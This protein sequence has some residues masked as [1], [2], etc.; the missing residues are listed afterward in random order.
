[1]PQYVTTEEQYY[2]HQIGNI[3]ECRLDLEKPTA[4]NTIHLKSIH[5]L[6]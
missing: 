1:M 4:T 6:D 3:I 2:V 5:E